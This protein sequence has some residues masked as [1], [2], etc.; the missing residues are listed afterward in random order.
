MASSSI[1]SKL[2]KVAIVQMK[3]TK[4]KVENVQKACNFIEQATNKHK[5]E[6]VVLPECFNCPY[7]TQYFKEYSEFESD[8]YTLNELKNQISK[9]PCTLVAGSIPEKS[10]T[11]NDKCYNTC[12]VINEKN[13]IIAKHRKIH[14]FDINVPGKMVF[15]ESLTLNPGNEITTFKYK[16]IANI[17][18]GICYDIRFNELANKMRNKFNTNLL[19]YPG[20]FNMTT[21]PAHWELLARAR[22]VDTQSYVIVCS[23]AR[24]Q[25][26]KDY[27]AY[28]HSSVF[29]P[30]A[31]CVGKLDEH[32][33]MLVLDLDM[34]RVD[35]VR[36]Q[37]PTSTQKRYDLYE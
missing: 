12:F 33:G 4:N 30:W 3:V 32:E 36:Q 21:G 28:G 29:S 10:K 7:G 31:D 16:D 35:Q 11:D 6:L 19:I 9:S 37:I 24:V 25:S 22:A 5:A 20:A 23:V 8:S 26:E 34:E 18:I 1:S 13:E 17:G 14:L 27:V 15:Q 2:L